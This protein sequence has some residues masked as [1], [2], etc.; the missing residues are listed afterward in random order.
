MLRAYTGENRLLAEALLAEADRAL[1]AD[2]ADIYVVVPRQLTLLTERMLL[3][4]LKKR[5]SFRLR[6]IAPARLCAEIFAAVGGPSGVRVDE[7]GRVMLIRRALRESENLSIYKNAWRRRGFAEKCAAEIESFLQGGVT[8]EQLRECAESSSGVQAAKLHDLAEVMEAYLRLIEDRYQDGEMELAAAAARVCE[9]QFT[10]DAHFFFYG[11]DIMPSTLITLIAQLSTDCADAAIFYPLI[12][13]EAARD[14]DCCAVLRLQLNRLLDK[15][16]AAG[17]T[18][19]HVVLAPS[20]RDDAIMALSRNLF[21]NPPKIYEAPAPNVTLFSSRDVREECAAAAAR[22][23]LLAIHGMHY[24]EMQLICMDMDGYRQPLEEAF[25]LYEVP[26]FLD[27]SRPVSR[28]APAEYMLTALRLLEK[29]F[30]S[31]DM[32]A[33]MRT[34][35]SP[36]NRDEADRMMNFAVTKGIEGGRWLR[37]L[38][39]GTEAEKA[40]HEPLREK[41]TAPL[42]ALR[43]EMRAAEN[44]KAQLTALFRFMEKT[45]TLEKSREMQRELIDKG[46]REQAGALAQAWNRI[47]GA[48]DQMAELMGTERMSLSELSDTL[49]ESLDAAIVKQLPQS[50][51]AVYAQD[52]RRMLMQK[53]R[54][55]FVLGMNDKNASAGDG[56]LSDAQRSAVAEQTR[57]WLGPDACGGTQMR[58]FYFK[59]ALAMAREKL[60]L[61][62]AMAAADGSAL[63]PA[64]AFEQALG[65]VSNA[66]RYNHETLQSLLAI[67]PEAAL[68]GVARAFARSRDGMAPAEL[69]VHAAAALRK[70]GEHMPDLHARLD[71]ITHLLGDDATDEHVDPNL[72]WKLY[73]HP[74]RTSVSRLELFA[75]CPFSYYVQ[76]GIKPVLVEPFETKSSDVGSFL[77]DAANAFLLENRDRLNRM[78]A[79]EARTLMGAIADRKL[80]ELRPSTPGEDSFSARARERKLREMACRCAEVFCTQMH[81]S[82]FSAEYLE[83][84]F[85]KESGA[86]RLTV[87]DTT[88]EGRID[89]VDCWHEGGRL[90]VIDYKLGGRKLDLAAAYYGLQMQLPIYLGAAMK[91]LGEKSAGVYYFPFTDGIV[92]SQSTNPVKIGQERSK[93]FQMSGLLPADDELIRAQAEDPETALGAK[94]KNDG[95]LYENIAR[96]SDVEFDRLIRHTLKKAKEQ[97]DA[98]R[99]G[100]ADVR[101]TQMSSGDACKWCK[102]RSACL[103]DAK[104][105]GRKQ[106]KF[107]TMGWSE[108]LEQMALEDEK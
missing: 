29:N 101:P 37:P 105:D 86:A 38:T 27:R 16:L 20:K 35:Y 90:R 40:E 57:T 55:V 98:I 77:H 45:N 97:I 93:Q 63:R 12:N 24:N 52:A 65:I 22:A 56:L 75:R 7:R 100:E 5:G 23:R 76:Y 88:L 19:A 87:G 108:A 71:G 26:L 79:A 36:L 2:D 64:I 8:V 104:I 81:G 96:A 1:S 53:A 11:F 72:T 78:D 83:E 32:F 91:K 107:K 48:L 66:K 62:C 85:G 94:M 43:R 3:G 59:S 4:G 82:S 10:R 51:D 47:V 73:D 50:D 13:D 42:A 9:A 18:R 58:N 17:G 44:L 80:E 25:A 84:G 61:S 49:R 21:A 60:Y 67:A 89:R 69:D 74:D 39:R 70:L 34:G 31:D 41:L 54:V 68:R 103:F 46:L 28:M 95:S 99:G 15:V 33:L 102:L 92:N 30:R 106:R 6:V 14:A